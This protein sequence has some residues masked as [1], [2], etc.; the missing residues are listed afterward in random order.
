MNEHFTS[1]TSI[2][3]AGE[4]SFIRWVRH[5]EGDAEWRN[6]VARHAEKQ[7]TVEEA[8]KIVL[9]LT[10]SA[11]GDLSSSGKDELWGRIH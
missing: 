8:R 7:I 2:T 9:S 11:I 4:D 10:G 5:G 1:Y 6:W 3:L